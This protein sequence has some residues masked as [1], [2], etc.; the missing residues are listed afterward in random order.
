MNV[1]IAG[2]L[3]LIIVAVVLVIG[4]N[5]WKSS[6]TVKQITVD[7][8]RIVGTNEIL[9][10][11]EIPRGTLLYRADLMA[12]Q[13]RVMGHYYVKD[14]LIERNLP[15]TIHITVTERIPIAMIDCGETLY[16]D[17]D[18]FILPR[19]ISRKLFDLPVISG[20]PE[21]APMK[22]GA[23]VTQPD[24]REALL[25]LGVMKEVNRPMYH[26]ISEVHVRNGGDIVLY[27][28][29]GGV[30]IIFGRGD[31][32]NKLVNLE[33]FWNE[34]VRV[35]GLQN[36]KYIDLRYEDQ[37]VV[38]WEPEPPARKIGGVL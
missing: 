33:A 12:I 25:L 37:I 10:L 13:R 1:R 29:E 2:L 32:S 15:S 31:V 14:A 7:G 5:A 17:E 22:L 35:R 23:I 30:P 3:G 24:L 38:R 4:A 36:L 8:N 27:S 16:L 28:A 19:T 34:V 6:L 21:H 18:G 11:T 26:N 20:M 9:Q